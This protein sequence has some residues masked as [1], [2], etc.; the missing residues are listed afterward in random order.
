LVLS[1]CGSSGNRED[2]GGSTTTFTS[3]PV[4]TTTTNLTTV[5]F[6]IAVTGA[7]RLFG[8]FV[9]TIPQSCSAWVAGGS[10]FA[11]PRAPGDSV[12]AVGYY[13]VVDVPSP[14]Y[15]GRGTYIIPGTAALGAVQVGSHQFYVEGSHLIV[16][17]DG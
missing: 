11:L 2:H 9:W 8:S 5:T 16:R 15:D 17:A 4:T 14:P 10:T 1:A 12:N 7:I 13:S 6:K 3:V